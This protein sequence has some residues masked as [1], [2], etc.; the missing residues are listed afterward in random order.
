MDREP[1]IDR[2]ACRCELLWDLERAGIAESPTGETLEIGEPGPWTPGRL[3]SLAAQASLMTEFL[4]LAE[5]ASLPVLGYLS[6]CAAR[7]GSRQPN[8]VALIL[9][10]CI[11][12][13]SQDDSACAER[14]LEEAMETS[15]VC[16][17]L[18]GAAEL[19]A[20]VVVAMRRPA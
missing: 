18:R 9:S 19:D 7:A 16:R 15:A 11:V 14:L 10:P 5:E 8:P 4:R 3:L 13:G 6:S 20:R 1:T 17:L 2:D 12:V